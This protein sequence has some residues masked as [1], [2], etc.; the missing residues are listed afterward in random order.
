MSKQVRRTG[1][2]R[3]VKNLA[4]NRVISSLYYA[5][6]SKYVDPRSNIQRARGSLQNSLGAIEQ[7]GFVRRSNNISCQARSSRRAPAATDRYYL[8]H[9]H[10]LHVITRAIT[11][12]LRARL[13]GWLSGEGGIAR[14]SDYHVMKDSPSF[15]RVAHSVHGSL[16]HLLPI[17]N[18]FHSIGGHGTQS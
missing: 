1:V 8:K 18:W 4:G 5:A 6:K 7:G 14:S 12:S 17:N 16:L 2:L 13:L 9:R 11:T 10:F 3:H 15:R